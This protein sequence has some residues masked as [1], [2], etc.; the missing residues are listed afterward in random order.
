M[1]APTPA[2]LPAENPPAK[3]PPDADDF[4]RRALDP[5]GP[6]AA[7]ATAHGVNLGLQALLAATFGAE[8]YGS[9]GLGL[10]AAATLCFIGEMGYPTLFLREAACRPDWLAA[11]RRALTRRVAG[12]ALAA[13]AAVVWRVSVAGWD[14]PGSLLLLGA[15]PGVVA[16]A[17]APTP[18]FYGLGAPRRA[19]A[20]VYSRWA[21]H[22]LGGLAAAA[23]CSADDVGLWMGVVFSAGMLAQIAA[24]FL[25]AALLSGGGLVPAAAFWPAAFWPAA[26]SLKAFSLAAFWPRAAAG[27]DDAID[28]AARRMWIM[29]CLGAAHAR[30][31]PFLVEATA[32]ALLAPTLFA[33]QILQGLGGLLGQF[34]RVTLPRLARFGEDAAAPARQ[35]SAA[36]LVLWPSAAAAPLLA[37]LALATAAFAP[38]AWGLS[39]ASAPVL[40]AVGGLLLLEW[41]IQMT[42]AAMTPI[43]LAKRRESALCA[44]I[45]QLTPASLA[46]QAGLAASGWLFPALGARVAAIAVIAARAVRLAEAERS[47]FALASASATFV[48]GLGALAWVAIEGWRS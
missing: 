30:A 13:A 12:L 23:F 6:A 32:P 46:L 37:A 47:R 28:A 26:F 17:F 8:I 27:R 9:L 22:G 36:R 33:H 41:Q 5:L 42:G 1:T 48:G 7:Q 45:V 20:T 44:V 3:R 34:D 35:R 11:W 43:I 25:P 10:I 18:I 14:D 4:V 31:L 39:G 15:A 38:P 29:A 16:S 24:A 21:A 40:A 2:P 19:A